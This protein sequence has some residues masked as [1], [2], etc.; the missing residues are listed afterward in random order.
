MATC[1]AK[2]IWRSG[3]KAEARL[4]EALT[5]F[6]HAARSTY[7]GRLFAEDALQGLR[8][9]DLSRQ[10]FDVIVMNPPFGEATTGSRTYLE[11]SLK[12]SKG[13]ILTHFVERAS[14]LLAPGGRLGALVSRSCFFIPSFASFRR[15]VLSTELSMECFADLGAGVLDAM[16]EVAA[17]T[18]ERSSQKTAPAHFL[19]ILASEDKPIDLKNCAEDFRSGT[20]NDKLF[21]HSVSNF[22][23]LD[24]APYVYWIKKEIINKIAK[25]PPIEPNA[26]QI[27][28]GLQTGDDFRFLRLWWEPEGKFNSEQERLRS[29]GLGEGRTNLNWAWYSKTEAASPYLSSIHLVVNWA[30]N[31]SEIKSYHIGNGHSASKYVM[32]ESLYFRPGFSYMLRSSRLVPYVVPSGVIPSAGRSQVYP[33]LGNE[34]WVAA[35]LGS[36]IATAVARF[37]GVNFLGSKF[38]NSMVASIP[39]REPRDGESQAALEKIVEIQRLMATRYRHDETEILFTTPPVGN[40]ETYAPYDRRS[41]LGSELDIQIAQGFG[42][43]KE[44]FVELERDYNEALFQGGKVPEDVDEDAEDFGEDDNPD[45]IDQTDGLLSWAA[46]VA[47]GRFDWRLATGERAAPPELEPFDPLP[48][49]S[50]GMLPDDADAVPRPFRHS[51][52]RPRASE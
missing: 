50:P 49:K 17:I 5:E 16:V 34:T 26:C 9:I 31:G 6:A 52:G 3:S 39:Y 41:L 27:R 48:A 7:Q 30:R 13:N 32:S 38:Q 24:D 8:M 46:G 10:H 11:Q 25:F 40:S 23:I 20:E 21:K 35:L 22:S 18:W 36:N 45:S 51:G 47:F 37:R 28:V 4:Q 42:I 15:T 43:S 19:R 14:Q 33:I 1:S 29:P 12:K 44:E 2:R